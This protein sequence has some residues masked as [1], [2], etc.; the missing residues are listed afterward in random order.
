MAVMPVAGA[1]GAGSDER[2][3]YWV[4]N[5]SDHDVLVDV[6]EQLHRTYLVPPHAYA[7]L[8]GGMGVPEDGWTLRLVDEDCVALQTF[9]VDGAHE[10]LDVDPEGLGGSAD[11]PPWSHGLR[12]A[13]SGTL[14]ERT[15]V[16]P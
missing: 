9:P 8:F 2:Y 13:T 14:H 12:T 5:D 15:P 16:C 3:S 11:D 7:P 1:S 4:L 10:L 6:R